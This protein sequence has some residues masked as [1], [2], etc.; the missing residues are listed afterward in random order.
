MGYVYL[1]GNNEQENVYK[2]GITR[3]K[4]ENRIKQLQTGSSGEIYLI[5]YHKT[6]YP[7]FIEKNFHMKYYPYQTIG[8]WFELT[9]DEV[10]KFKEICQ[11]FEN[12]AKILE[13]NA[14]AKNI[15]K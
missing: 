12:N 4:I 3:G 15:L 11:F 7:F 5:N 13:E 9:S 6:K 2:I 1:L 8:E 14:F 10:L